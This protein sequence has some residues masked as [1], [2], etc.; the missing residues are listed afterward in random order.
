MIPLLIL[1]AL[2]GLMQAARTFTDDIAIGGTELAFGYLLLVAFFGGRVVSRI[3]L[4]RLTGYLIAGVVS[5]PFVLALITKGMGDSLRMVNGVAT[6]ILGLVA[7]AELNLKKVRPLRRTLAAMMGLGVVGSMLVLSG[8]LFAMRSLIPFL[9]GLDTGPALA[10]CGLVGVALVPQSPAIVMAMLGE[11]K[12]DGPLSQ[13][14]LA[15]VVVADLVVVMTYSIVA[16]VTG[17]VI[18]GE[19]DV[20]GTALEVGWELV[21]SVAF[22]V[23]IGFLIGVFVQNVKQ[24]APMFALMLCVVV[25]EIGRLVHLDPLI[26][27]LAAGIFLENFSRADASALLH[28]F[29]SAQLPVFL[30]WFALAGTRLDIDALVATIIPVMIL[31][32]ARGAWFWF[33]CRIATARTHAADAVKRFGWIGLL[34]QAGLSLALVVVIQKNFPSFGKPAAAVLLSVVALNQLVSPVLLRLALVK[35]GEA[36]KKADADFGDAH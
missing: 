30:V 24:G 32:T 1:L 18:G 31:A 17:A 22:G 15:S 21:G 4:P 9:A 8:V 27:M 12:A 29:E 19:L 26:V 36:G 3:G 25:A 23:A 6:C 14:A 20:V 33:G 28:G 2:G 16:A 11:T 10:V 7:G 5:G 35:S 13:M 34:P